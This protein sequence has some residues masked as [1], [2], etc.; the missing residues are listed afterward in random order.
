[1][2]ENQR[3]LSDFISSVEQVDAPNISAEDLGEK[4][5]T[6]KSKVFP[7]IVGILLVLI[8]GMGGYYVYKEYFAKEEVST[9]VEDLDTEINNE[10]QEEGSDDL[11]TEILVPSESGGD[12]KVFQLSLPE[13]WTINEDI[14]Y[15]SVITNGFFSIYIIKDPIVTGGGWGFMYDGV[16]N[17]ETL[18]SPLVI[19]GVSVNKVTHV[20][21]KDIIKDTDLENVFGGSVFSSLDSNISTP[22]LELGKENYLIKYLYEGDQVISIDSQEYKGAIGTMDDIIENIL[23]K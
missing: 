19:N 9:T 7:V 2:A 21:P 6:E 1:M 11:L 12:D 16:G 3:P 13:G 10:T 17:Y 23:I 14:N 5:K 22:S 18:V 8:L 15:A 4:P 20:L